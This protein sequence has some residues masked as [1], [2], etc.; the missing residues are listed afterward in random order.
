MTINSG[1]AFFCFCFNGPSVLNATCRE[2]RCI[3]TGPG[4]LYRQSDIRFFYLKT[5]FNVIQIFTKFIHI[6]YQT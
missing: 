6:N 3:M 1:I 5:F 2:H 4:R